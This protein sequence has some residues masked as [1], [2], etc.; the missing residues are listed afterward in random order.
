MNSLL[1]NI[2]RYIA[3][4]SQMGRAGRGGQPSV[5]IFPPWEA[6]EVAEG[7]ETVLQGRPTSLPEEGSGQHLSVDRH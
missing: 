2:N 4:L 3:L 6:T 1:T 7:D 5:C